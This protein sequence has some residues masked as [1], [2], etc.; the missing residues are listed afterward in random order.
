MT[1]KEL[2]TD[3]E[4]YDVDIRDNYFE[5]SNLCFF[6]D[7]AVLNDFGNTISENRTYEQMKLIIENLFDEVKL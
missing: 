7:G 2:I 3:L 6:M 4:K 1:W 5:I